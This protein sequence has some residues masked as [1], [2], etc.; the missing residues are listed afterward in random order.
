MT[1][2]VI[3][4]FGQWAL[5]R[6]RKLK[7]FQTGSPNVQ[8][9]AKYREIALIAKLLKQPISPE[10]TALAEKAKYSQHM[11]TAAEGKQFDHHLRTATQALKRAPLPKRLIAKWFWAAY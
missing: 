6:Y 9:L 2:C 8:A 4:F 3:A 5:R 10:L 7:A 1:V 11:L